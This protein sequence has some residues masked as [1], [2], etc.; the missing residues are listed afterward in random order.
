M[1]RS[2]PA[3]E[4]YKNS[5]ARLLVMKKGPFALGQRPTSIAELVNSTCG[6]TMGF[7]LEVVFIW[8]GTPEWER[9]Q[10]AKAPTLRR[11]LSQPT[12]SRLLAGVAGKKRA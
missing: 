10:H 11:G 6:F 12:S 4:H 1:L 8:E 5:N 2:Y 9:K 7:A 3:S